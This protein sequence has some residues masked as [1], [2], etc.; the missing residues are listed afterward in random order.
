MRLEMR[1]GEVLQGCSPRGIDFRF[2]HLTSNG[3]CATM[4]LQRVVM[5]DRI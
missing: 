5:Q 3:A 2:A 4:R 1:E